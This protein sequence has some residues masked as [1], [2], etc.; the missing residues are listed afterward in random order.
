MSALNAI[1]PWLT[2]QNVF[3]ATGTSSSS[4]STLP[5][6]G[7]TSFS[8]ILKLLDT[9]ADGQ[10]GADELKFGAGFMINNL[11]FS[12]DLNQD[13]LLSSEETGVPQALINYF[14]NNGDQMLSA[15]EMITPADQIIDGVVSV[16][17]TNGDNQLSSEELGIIDLI[18][19]LISMGNAGQT[20]S[21]VDVKQAFDLDT[22]P[23]RMRQAGFE[24]TDNQLYY[25]LASTYADW[26][27]QPDPNDPASM[28]LSDQRADIYKWFDHIVSDVGRQ[29]K[30]NPYLSATAVI[31]DGPDRLGGRLGPA[32]LKKLN[33]FG[34]RVQMGTLFEDTSQTVSESKA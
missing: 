14:D 26:P 23:D 15:K 13:S 9:N 25:A 29:M 1:S 30:A 34:D 18:S 7:P 21:P 31:N 20:S 17:D 16:L 3:G 32:I 28:K 24:G 2:T 6:T 33:S 4:S 11:V 27:W 8:D 5:E 22:I 19:N 12:Q 10:T